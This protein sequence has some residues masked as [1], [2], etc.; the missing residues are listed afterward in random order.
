MKIKFY[1]ITYDNNTVLNDWTLE[2]LHNSNFPRDKV[3]IFVTDNHSNCVI[4][5]KYK[6]FVTLVPNNLRPDFST[7][8]Q[9]RSHNQALVNG[10]KSLVNPDCD[11]VVS[12]QNDSKVTYDW[13][14]NLCE[15]A[16]TYTFISPGKGD[17]F[18]AFLP[19]AVRRIGLFDERLANVGHSEEDYYLRALYYNT[20]QST[21]CDYCHRRLHNVTDGG[22]IVKNTATG[23]SRRDPHHVASKNHHPLAAH[24]LYRK[25]G[26]YKLVMNWPDPATSMIPHIKECLDEAPKNYVMYPYFEKDVY[27]LAGK[28]YDIGD[29]WMYNYTN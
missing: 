16:K 19:E 28:N 3:E 20:E 15:M 9:A 11:M 29:K 2:S 10:F 13:Y 24:I 6:D 7:G 8:H 17:Q 4:N 22:L 12:S 1:I 25:W 21:I 23:H 14:D 5:D 18:L 26:K 27:D